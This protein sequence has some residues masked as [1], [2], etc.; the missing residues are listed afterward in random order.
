MWRGPG[1]VE[2]QG[3]K[4]LGTPIGHPEYVR[5]FLFS[6]DHQTLLNGIPLIGDVQAAWLL[7]VH[8]TASR[9][10]IFTAVCRP[11]RFAR[12]HDQN[13]MECLSSILHVDLM[14]TRDIATLPMSLGHSALR[15]SKA[16]HWA[17]WANCLPMILERYPD[18]ARLLVGQLEQPTT[19]CLQAV[20]RVARD[21]T[22]VR[23]FE[24]H[25]G[26]SWQW[27]PEP[28]EPE[29]FEP[30]LHQRWVAT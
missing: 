7:L 2:E 25:L 16:A 18:V 24:H 27:E 19:P 30:G 14:G 22:G 20:A 29:D 8:C 28:R 21:L 17:S 3:I 23:G 11:R 13:M 12:R 15:T 5:R 26:G 4:I 1:P 6:V 10:D 9:G